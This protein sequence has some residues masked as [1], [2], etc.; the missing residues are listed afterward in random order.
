MQHC[1]STALSLHPLSLCS[2]A[3]GKF[4]ADGANARIDLEHK[5]LGRFGQACPGHG[6]DRV[7]LGDPEPDVPG[8]SPLWNGFPLIFYDTGA[9]VAGGASGHIFLV[10]R[11]PVYSELLFLAGGAFS[12]WPIVGLQALMTSYLILTVARIE[13]PGPDACGALGDRG[14]AQRSP[15]ELAGMWARSNPTSSRPRSSWVRIC[16]SFAAGN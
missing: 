13:V 12:L 10:E 14:S 11:A 7:R 4:P 5:D 2:A 1:Q 16:C 3:C 9:Y 6:R 15:P 8:A